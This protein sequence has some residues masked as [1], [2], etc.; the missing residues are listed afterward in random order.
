MENDIIII[1]FQGKNNSSRRIT[2]VVG[3]RN[4]LKRIPKDDAQ[5]KFFIDEVADM[6]LPY[7]RN[8]V[9]GN[10]VYVINSKHFKLSNI[11]YPLVIIKDNDVIDIDE[12][13][14]SPFKSILQ[15]EYMAECVYN[16]NGGTFDAGTSDAYYLLEDGFYVKCTNK[17][18]SDDV[19][20]AFR[21]TNCTFGQD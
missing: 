19:L 5:R 7:G 8:E 13:W 6:E 15:N 10:I 12:W 20:Y 11:Q 2:T 14:Y 18:D 21:A 3:E 16:L 9:D 4:F 17:Q 1:L